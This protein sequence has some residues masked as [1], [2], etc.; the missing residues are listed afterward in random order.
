MR[1]LEQ[2]LNSQNPLSRSTAIAEGTMQGLLPAIVFSTEDPLGIG[3]VQVECPLIAP[4]EI[5]PHEEDNWIPVIEQFVCNGKPGG[6][7]SLL[8]KGVQVMLAPRFGST[9]QSPSWVV[10]GAIHSTVDKLHPL[11]DRTKG[12]W[13][14]VTPG[15]KIE[16]NDDKQGSQIISH[17][18]GATMQ[19]SKEGDITNQTKGGAR[20]HLGQDGALR[21]ENEKSFTI[22]D[23]SGQISAG[24]GG[25]ASSVLGASGNVNVASGSGSS[26]SLQSSGTMSGGG[27]SQLALSELSRSSDRLQVAL[28]EIAASTSKI[29]DSKV[30]DSSKLANSLQN[31]WKNFQTIGK[32]L[33][34]LQ[35]SKPESL[36]ISNLQE[37]SNFLRYKLD[38]LKPKINATL[39]RDWRSPDYAGGLA[40]IFLDQ[41]IL[42]PAGK[43]D[44]IA[45]TLQNLRYNRKIQ[46]NFL[47]SKL[48]QDD[49]CP[50]T[51]IL[52]E[53]ELEPVLAQIA[54]IPAIQLDAIA[55]LQSLLPPKLQGISTEIL[56]RAIALPPVERVGCL[57]GA[58]RAEDAKALH[59]EVS[60][61]SL[62]S[63][64]ESSNSGSNDSNNASK[65]SN[66]ASNNAPNSLESAPQEPQISPEQIVSESAKQAQQKI[67]AFLGSIPSGSSAAKVTA[68]ATSAEMLSAGGA[69]KVAAQPSTA[70]LQSPAGK[71]EAGAGGAGMSGGGGSVGVSGDGVGMSGKG[72]EKVEI[73][74]G[75]L[76][77][78]GGG[79]GAIAI[80]KDDLILYGQGGATI[81][82]ANAKIEGNADAISFVAKSG[83]KLELNETG[84]A[85]LQDS[86]DGKLEIVE[87]ELSLQ[88]KGDRVVVGKAIEI[89][90]GGGAIGIAGTAIAVAA[91][92]LDIKSKIA[93]ASEDFKLQ[94]GSTVAV[95]ASPTTFK[96]SYLDNALTL[97]NNSLI[98]T[99]IAGTSSI[100]A[101]AVELIGGANAA[102]KFQVKAEGFFADG[103]DVMG[104]IATNTTKIATSESK[105]QT[106]ES[107]TDFGKLEAQGVAQFFQEAQG[108]VSVTGLRTTSILNLFSATSPYPGRLGAIAV[109]PKAG[110]TLANGQRIGFTNRK[111]TERR[112]ATN[113]QAILS[114]GAIKLIYDLATDSPTGTE[115]SSSFALYK[116]YLANGQ[117]V[118][119][120]GTFAL[121]LNNTRLTWTATSGN[122]LVLQNTRVW[123]SL[124]INYPEGAGIAEVF[125]TFDAAWVSN[126]AIAN[127]N[128]RSTA[129][130]LKQYEAPANNEN[131]IV[132]YNRA[133]AGIEYIYRKLTLTSDAN[134]I[135][136][137]PTT[138][139]GAI[140]FVE[141]TGIVRYDL[142][143]IINV[144]A[145]TPYNVLVYHTPSA[146]ELWQFQITSR[147]Y[148]GT[149]NKAF[150]NGATIATMPLLYVHT[151][152][153]GVAIAPTESALGDNAIAP[154]LPTF[155]A[156]TTSRFVLDGV[157][158]EVG[159]STSTLTARFKRFFPLPSAA[160]AFPAIGQT[161]KTEDRTTPDSRTIAAALLS[162][163]NKT[164]G[165]KM[166][167]ITAQY[168]QYVLIFVT[169]KNGVAMLVICTQNCIATLNSS[170]DFLLD[171]DATAIDTFPLQAIA[172]IN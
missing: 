25:G 129:N 96:F 67:K 143:I 73:S 51:G 145:N 114:S 71:V 27:S 38:V 82:L 148:Q 106:L 30:L 12:K 34:I 140:A 137:I 89:G 158:R 136:T 156:P 93:I 119:N 161:I 165:V 19:I 164:F 13:G 76:S 26:L 79:E 78:G 108:D 8:E 4:G 77:M 28:T 10:M 134:G 23:P 65:S 126:T 46:V 54:A 24:N 90:Q 66:D 58:V 84:K 169:I 29:A 9:Q 160:L 172:G 107:K 31:V 72:G 87:G 99:N 57:I 59:N 33:E 56:T 122:S 159:E 50:E 121:S 11:L 20:S 142:P 144:G 32:S 132:F 22:H 117:E 64:K 43:L 125:A 149:K 3:R 115:F 95:Q 48:L 112:A 170:V 138:I 70:F 162:A 151:Q 40:A 116:I 104:A 83:N 157:I 152:G 2:I 101:Q 17:P 109:S 92:S 171:S 44:A 1:T 88:G 103:T 105:I 155:D 81:S 36:G 120:T 133:T 15:G 168:F 55:V 86:K 85:I 21:I 131:L 5:L 123:T 97:A 128:I 39:D 42:M 14:S 7:H 61:L 69:S 167:L 16:I 45:L 124:A 94:L 154:W 113:Q 150:L 147:N 52:E 153:G 53:L 118:S 146:A 98:A 37:V 63:S 47:L 163:D 141:G 60:K 18:N 6:S 139:K 130:D 68:G 74:A 110:N 135:I 80:D 75:K 35:T 111:M 100:V 62:N 102:H 166:P 41:Q 49:Y 127:A 91:S